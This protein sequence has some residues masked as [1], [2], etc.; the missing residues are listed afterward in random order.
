MHPHTL[1]V[2]FAQFE[3]VT[4]LVLSYCRFRNF[5]QFQHLIC[6]LPR[7][8][9]LTIGGL[10]SRKAPL[11]HN[12]MASQIP[13]L[14]HILFYNSDDLPTAS[15]LLKWLSCISS[16]PTLRSL[17]FDLRQGSIS[18]MGDVLS[19]VGSSLEHLD[20]I[21]DDSG[22]AL[23]LQQLN[24]H[25][26]T[27]LRKLTLRHTRGISLAGILRA[28]PSDTRIHEIVIFM[29]LG[30]AKGEWECASDILEEEQFRALSTFMLTIN[31]RSLT[32]QEKC[33]VSDVF[34]VLRR[35]GVTRQGWRVLRSAPTLTI[36]SL[37]PSTAGLNTMTRL[38]G[39]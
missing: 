25:G 17:Y 7:L 2:G 5:R 28:I 38:R 29:T 11:P 35:R 20:L 4:E 37:L 9:V 15:T 23:D 24:V 33:H 39:Q 27:A 18:H 14:T 16:N 31:D 34:D 19:A 12:V 22:S 13:P 30:N 8:Q 32:E 6:A 1:L 36:N 26:C 21:L 3:F 10:S